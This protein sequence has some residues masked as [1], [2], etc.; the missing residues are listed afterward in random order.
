MRNPYGI[1]VISFEVGDCE[2]LSLPKGQEI[3]WTE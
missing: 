2:N 3:T 1:G